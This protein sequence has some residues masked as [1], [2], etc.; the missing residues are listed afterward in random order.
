MLCVGTRGADFFRKW[1][2]KENRSF[3]SELVR[4]TGETG[5]RK[6]RKRTVIRQH[7]QET[8]NYYHNYIIKV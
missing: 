1:L 2:F 4:R 5:E 3:S 7:H 8:H 6:R